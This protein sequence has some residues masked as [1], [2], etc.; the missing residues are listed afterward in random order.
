MT[1]K[2]KNLPIHVFNNKMWKWFMR[3]LSDAILFEYVYRYRQQQVGGRNTCWDKIKKS[4][5]IDGSGGTHLLETK[6]DCFFF[7]DQ[8]AIRCIAYAHLSIWN[9]LFN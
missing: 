4:K 8:L 1:K 6:T 3:E 2:K 9:N 7:F 5:T